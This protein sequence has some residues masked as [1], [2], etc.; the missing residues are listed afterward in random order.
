MKDFCVTC[1]LFTDPFGKVHVE[2]V[3]STIKTML[4]AVV[5]YHENLELHSLGD[6]KL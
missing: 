2:R 6:V 3:V 5:S 1:I 4:T